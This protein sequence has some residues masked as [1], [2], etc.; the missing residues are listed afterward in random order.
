M[1]SLYINNTLDVELGA[2]R[3]SSIRDYDLKA[4]SEDPSF[5]LMLNVLAGS[6]GNNYELCRG[7]L[8]LVDNVQQSL[9]QRR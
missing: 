8:G 6:K 3:I 2:E 9:G 5:H 4:M 1:R 7:Q